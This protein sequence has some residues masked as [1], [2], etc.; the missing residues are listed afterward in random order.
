MSTHVAPRSEETYKQWCEEEGYRVIDVTA[1]AKCEADVERLR[2]S[3]LRKK[4]TILLL[5]PSDN[6]L[7]MMVACGEGRLP[8]Y[9]FVHPR[10]YLCINKGTPCSKAAFRNILLNYESEVTCLICDGEE[11]IWSC[12][13]CA[14]IT[15]AACLKRI[16]GC[17]QCRSSYGTAQFAVFYVDR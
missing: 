8:D 9:L 1:I 10:N 2:D 11:D 14:Y 12:P 15:C 7:E 13:T 6:T 16:S 3:V 17:P 4:S 5:K